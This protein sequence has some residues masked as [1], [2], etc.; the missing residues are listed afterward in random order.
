MCDKR[1]GTTSSPV[2]YVVAI[3]TLWSVRGCQHHGQVAALTVRAPPWP[4]EQSDPG[5]RSAALT[6]KRPAHRRLADRTRSGVSRYLPATWRSPDFA[7]NPATSFTLRLYEHR[8]IC[9]LREPRCAPEP[10][11]NRAS[12]RMMGALRIACAHAVDTCVD[13]GVSIPGPTQLNGLPLKIDLAP[14]FTLVSS[15]ICKIRDR[16]PLSDRTATS[17][18]RQTSDGYP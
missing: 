10:P 16:T 14:K 3:L 18:T 8:K 9:D 5:W 6:A 7:S 2:I 13:A 4:P 17:W 15:E 12:H 1:Q 11:Y